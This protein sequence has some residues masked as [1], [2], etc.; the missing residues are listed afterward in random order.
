MKLK[1]LVKPISEQTDEELQAR[2]R[3]IRHR[4]ETVRPAAKKIVARIEEKAERKKV[5]KI[6]GLLEGL[7]AEEKLKLMQQLLTDEGGSNE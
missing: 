7:S 2:L 6:Q 1:D 5:S 4:R 3:E